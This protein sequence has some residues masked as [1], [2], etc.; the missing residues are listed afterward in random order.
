VAI[1]G[2]PTCA[3]LQRVQHTGTLATLPTR[4]K[5]WRVKL[6]DF[7][8]SG[9]GARTRFVTR[10]S[11]AASEEEFEI[12]IAGPGALTKRMFGKAEFDLTIDSGRSQD[13]VIADVEPAL[14]EQQRSMWAS[15]ALDDIDALLKPPPARPEPKSTVFAAIRPVAGHGTPFAFIATSFFVPAGVSFFFFGS[16]VFTAVGSLVPMSGDQDLYLRLFSPTSPIVAAS[17]GIGTSLDVVWF[18]FPLFPVVPVFEVRGWATGVCSTLTA[19]G[20]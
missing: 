10:V 20:A 8:K 19:S 4:P 7:E 11:D 12:A 15:A 2:P 13:Q 18:T 5:A 14:R 1:A 3:G 17:R 16:F 6:D 9:T